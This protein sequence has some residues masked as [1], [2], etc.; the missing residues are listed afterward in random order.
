MKRIGEKKF[1]LSILA[2]LVFTVLH[3]GCVEEQRISGV[4]Y[5]DGTAR[6]G[7]NGAPDRPFRTLTEALQASSDDFEIR[8]L[9]GAYPEAVSLGLDVTIVGVAEKPV[10]GVEGSEPAI[11]V[12][13]NQAVHLQNVSI[14]GMK[15]SE[16]QVHLQDVVLSSSQGAALAAN[17]TDVVATRISVSEG[18]VAGIH[19]QGGSLVLSDSEFSHIVGSAVILEH[20]TAEISR[21]K[22]NEITSSGQGSDDGIGLAAFD[23]TVRIDSS[24][25]GQ[26]GNRGILFEASQ[27]DVINCDFEAIGRSD[28]AYIPNEASVIS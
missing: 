28:I 22:F 12:E 25:F 7:G 19:L 9:P 8:L 21:V 26:I 3:A 2:A 11:T 24:E 14:V 15:S 5:V 23:A 17:N 18:D 10:L 13:A 1:R 27:G 20:S 4:L 16:G 6:A